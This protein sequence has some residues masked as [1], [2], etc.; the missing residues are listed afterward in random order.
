MRPLGLALVL[1][2]GLVA[3]PLAAA[4]PPG[5][6]EA[7]QTPRFVFYATPRARAAAR[8]LAARAE[9]VRDAIAGDLGRDYPGRTE[10]RVAEDA[11]A[12]Q[13]LQ[14]PGAH[15]PS[16]AA[17]VAFPGRNLVVLDVM[18]GPRRDDP[19]Q[20]LAHE[21]SHLALER[22]A[23]GRFPRWFLEGMA[24]YQAGSWDFGRAAVLAGAVVR[25][26]IIDL[27]DLTE[28][29]P[30]DPADVQVAYAESIA[31]VSWLER[32]HGPQAVHRLVDRVLGGD[33]FV[34][35]MEAATSLPLWRLERSFESDLR[36]RYTWLPAVTS[37][38]FVW[39]LTSLLFVL[40]WVRKRRQ[41]RRGMEALVEIEEDDG[42]PS[43]PE[44][45]LAEVIPLPLA[46]SPPDS[47]HER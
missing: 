40:V 11:S 4:P 25:H 3:T 20:I 45:H 28:G 32:E 39:G 9:G 24:T 44:P 19:D 16:W 42:P 27:D 7:A 21:V 30:H 15:V 2:A 6:V 18:G 10:V 14:P 37:T 12:F 31:F 29:W 36:M 1:L 17:G 47:A 34:P 43:E 33:D 22:L 13:A 5:T 46:P 41:K 35:A 26:Q 38:G 23:P 8:A